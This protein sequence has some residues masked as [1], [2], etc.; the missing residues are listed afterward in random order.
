MDGASKFVRGDA[1]AAIIMIIVN[2]LGGFAVG[3]AQRGMDLDRR[4]CR[5]TRCSRSVRDWSPRFPRCW[6]P[7]RP[8]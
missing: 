8:V 6:S 7:P 5:P 1:I 2:V 3:V 4:T